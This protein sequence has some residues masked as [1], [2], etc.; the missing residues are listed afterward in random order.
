M[1]ELWELL[2]DPRFLSRLFGSDAP[3]WLSGVVQPVFLVLLLAAIVGSLWKNLVD[4]VKALFFQ[5]RRSDAERK[6][7]DVRRQFVQHLLTRLNRLDREDDWNRRRF[8][9]LE[10]EYYQ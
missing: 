5:L 9:E 4:P 2:S 3:P 6:R 1:K 7:I 8:T 10:T